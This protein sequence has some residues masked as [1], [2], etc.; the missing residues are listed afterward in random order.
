LRIASPGR[1]RPSRTDCSSL[2]APID[3]AWC[4]RVRRRHSRES[5]ARYGDNL[6][7]SNR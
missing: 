1:D 7:F 3:S 6:P 5:G 2:W 4:L